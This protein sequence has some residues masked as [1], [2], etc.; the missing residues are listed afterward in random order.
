MK[1]ATKR[2][3]KERVQS[4]AGE[5]ERLEYLK[6][7]KRATREQTQ[8][9]QLTQKLGVEIRRSD[10]AVRELWIDLSQR[11]GGR[12]DEAAAGTGTDG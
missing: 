8:I 2:T 6:V 5:I 4:A 9:R 7:L 3:I 10:Q 12:V 1:K 11:F